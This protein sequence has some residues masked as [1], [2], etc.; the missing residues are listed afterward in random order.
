MP[1]WAYK[2]STKKRSYED[3]KELA[4]AFGFLARSAYRRM[5]DGRA[6]G[7]INNVAK[8]V[9]GDVLHV[10][11]I[12]KKGPHGMGSFRVLEPSASSARFTPVWSDEDA[13]LAEVRAVGDNKAL[14]DFL[15]KPPISGKGYRP[16]PKLKVFTG[17][18]V[19]RIP[20][21]TP[22]RFE[23]IDFP[24]QNT[25]VSVGDSSREGGAAHDHLLSRV[26][27]DP[28]IMGGKPCIRGT[29]VTVSMILGL[30]ASGHSF[31]A[32]LADF[33]YLHEIDVRAALAYAAWRTQERDLPLE[34][35]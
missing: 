18:L 22:P 17:W 6:G 4:E 21:R 8:V 23:D 2:A 5:K 26:V 28:D 7:R 31:E 20:G 29:R 30:L 34:A 13:A 27:H 33:P 35:A 16:D 9:P 25:L 11:Y 24:G 15:Q 32:I 19:E 14:L 1:E 3:T 12:D 10:Y